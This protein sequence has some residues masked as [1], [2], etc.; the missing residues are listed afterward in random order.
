MTQDA[1]EELVVKN[2]RSTAQL[3]EVS[4]RTSLDVDKLTKHM[5]DSISTREQFFQLQTEV[6]ELKVEIYNDKK[7]INENFKKLAPV[8]TALRYPYAAGLAALGVVLLLIYEI[9]SP[10]SKQIAKFLGVDIDG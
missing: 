4:K 9:R 1:L 7:D 3:V 8:F 5:E 2:L 10:I 6:Q